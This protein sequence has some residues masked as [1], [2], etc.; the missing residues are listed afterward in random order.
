MCIYR[1]NKINLPKTEED[2]A[3]GNGEGCY[4]LFDDKE[5]DMYDSDARGKGEVIL[6]NDSV[7]YPK[8]KHGTK[9]PVEYRGENRPVVPLSWLQQ[10]K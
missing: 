8:L 2:Y 5:S 7:Y 6:D 3:R 1:T 4:A 9:V 10:Y